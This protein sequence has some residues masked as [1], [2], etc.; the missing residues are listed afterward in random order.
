MTTDFY[1]KVAK[2]FGGYAYGRSNPQYTTEYLNGV[3]EDI[4]NTKLLGVSGLDKVVLDTGCGDCK[5]TFEIAGNFKKIVGID[6]SEEL[7]KIAKQKKPS[8][9]LRNVSIFLQDAA[10]TGFK[11]GSFDIIYS[12]RG[13]TYYQEYFR[14]LKMGGY[15]FEI[16]VGEKDCVEIKE[17]FQR[18]QNYEKWNESKLKE[19]ERKVKDIG[20]KVIFAQDYFYNKYYR[21]YNDL[22]LF[23]QTVPIFEDF[24]SEED[25]IFLKE[26]TGKYKEEKGIKLPCHRIIMQLEK[27]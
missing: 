2:K 13:P 7:L 4:F 10:K 9:G 15:Y 22:D 24:D 17:I 5:Y 25:K 12:R 16:A 14:L 6:T 23:L 26:Y 1:N 18:G 8:S 19:K 20:F 11:D 21:S 27:I 3:P